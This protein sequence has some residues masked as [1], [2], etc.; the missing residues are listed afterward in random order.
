MIVLRGRALAN[1]V[2]LGV[3]VILLAVVWLGPD[4]A[5]PSTELLSDIDP[6]AVTGVR[7]EWPR[8]RAM[9]ARRDAERWQMEAPYQLPADDL[10][11]QALLSLARAP[12]LAHFPASQRELAQFGLDPPRVRIVLDDAVFEFGDT[13]PLDGRRYVLHAGRVHVVAD[14]HFQHLSAEAASYLHPGPMGPDAEPVELLVSGARLRLEDGR[15]R[16]EPPLAGVSADRIN[17][18]ADEWAR[19]RAMSV[20]RFDPNLNWTQSVAV[21]RADETGPR[22]FRVAR[23]DYELVLGRPD[24]GIQYHV[25]RKSGERLLDVDGRAEM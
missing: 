22:R 11:M 21:R 13:E 8:G 9:T 16:R 7:I 4:R 23:T 18:L 14:S 20:S 12:S 3:T 19:V 1:I 15:W 6:G 17:A 24:A 5:Q 2:L 10:R 25:M